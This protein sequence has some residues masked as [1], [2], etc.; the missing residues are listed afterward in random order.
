MIST[1]S[2]SLSS[3]SPIFSRPG[4]TGSYYY[5]Q[6]IRV[7]VP[8]AGAY[9][10]SSISSIDTF[11]YFYND[12]VDPSNP[13]QNLITSDDDSGGG[14]QFLIV[15]YL[16]SASSYVLIVTTYSNSVFGSFSLR[17]S[18]PSSI[19]LT[20]FNPSTS[21]PISTTSESKLHA[22][23][24][25]TTFAFDLSRFIRRPVILFWILIS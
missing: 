3:R 8:T 24:L 13:S 1:L 16:S 6:A 10:F 11:G 25:I 23:D 4:N 7:T 22:Y 9:T 19:D 18:G 15:R 21:R 14:N 2:G 12:P 20:A 17:V 5:Y